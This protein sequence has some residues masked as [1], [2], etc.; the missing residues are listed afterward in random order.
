MLNKKLTAKER[1]WI[2][3]PICLLWATQL[4]AFPRQNPGAVWKI[5]PW[6]HNFQTAVWVTLHLLGM[7]SPAMSFPMLFQQVPLL[8]NFFPGC[9]GMEHHAIL[10]KH[11]SG[12]NTVLILFLTFQYKTK[13]NKSILGS[14]G[15][16]RTPRRLTILWTLGQEHRN[17]R[18]KWP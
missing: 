11:N 4:T 12:Y 13:E 7:V 5:F 14:A 18:R 2:L 1:A 6:K 16:H 3:H 15:H 9:H 8:S 17:C 10:W